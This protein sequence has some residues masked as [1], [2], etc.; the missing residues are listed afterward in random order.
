MLLEYFLK[1]EC[2]MQC[3]VRHAPNPSGYGTCISTSGSTLKASASAGSG[4]YNNFEIIIIRRLQSG[5]SRVYSRKGSFP[6]SRG[7]YNTEWKNVPTGTYQSH[8]NLFDHSGNPVGGYT[9][10]WHNHIAR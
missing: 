10:G 9:T 3:S 2:N 5:T 4:S 7:N 1:G 6:P 8:L